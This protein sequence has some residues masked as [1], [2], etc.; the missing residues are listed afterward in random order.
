[1]DLIAIVLAI[2]LASPFI[3]AVWAASLHWRY[4]LPAEVEPDVPAT[5]LA[6]QAPVE[7]QTLDL[8]RLMHDTS[9]D[10]AGFAASHGVRVSLAVSPGRQ[11]WADPHTLSLALREALMAAIRAARGGHVLVSALPLGASLHIAITDDGPH[12]GPATRQADMT[13]VAGAMAAMGGSLSIENRPGQSTT[14]TLRLA[15]TPAITRPPA[16]PP[17]LV[18]AA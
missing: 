4:A 1:M 15:R 13:G 18:Q 3:L 7:A 16:E 14:V 2:V 11:V 10:L 12:H 9:F 5:P 8:S 17:L 6:I